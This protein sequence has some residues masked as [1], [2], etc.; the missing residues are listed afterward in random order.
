MTIKPRR[1]DSAALFIQSSAPRLT[2]ARQPT[3]ISAPARARYSAIRGVVSSSKR[4]TKRLPVEIHEDLAKSVLCHDDRV[5]GH[6]VEQFVGVDDA[7]DLGGQSR[8]AVGEQRSVRPERL[9]LRGACGR[10]LL[11]EG[12][13]NGRVELGVRS[14]RPVEDVAGQASSCP[15]RPRP[16]RSGGDR[17]SGIWDWTWRRT[18]HISANCFASN[19]PKIGPTS[20]LV[21]KSPAR[22]VFWAAR[23]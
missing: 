4:S 15:R 23:A 21:K 19:S 9:D 20:T 17:G 18:R 13:A 2:S 3:R 6:R 8:A 22:P 7:V 14:L 1:S 11:D 12:Q 5:R 10:R 16:D